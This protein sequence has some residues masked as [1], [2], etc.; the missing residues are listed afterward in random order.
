MRKSKLNLNDLNDIKT[1]YR[2]TESEFEYYIE[3]T[4]IREND[5]DFKRANAHELTINE[6]INR[7][8]N[9]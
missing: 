3:R 1:H 6:I 2:L 4:G 9:D 8:R 5:A 7:R